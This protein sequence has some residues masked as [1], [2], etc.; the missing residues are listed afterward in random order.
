MARNG[1]CATRSGEGF[2]SQPLRLIVPLR[3]RNFPCFR[4]QKPSI[5]SRALELDYVDD[6]AAVVGIEEMGLVEVNPRSRQ[7]HRDRVIVVEMNIVFRVFFLQ[8]LLEKRKIL[9][10][11]FGKDVVLD[12]ITEIEE[13]EV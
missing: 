3:E 11:G 7:S 10:I 1:G 4:G 6:P 12:V 8:R 9:E 2:G 13:K 5:E